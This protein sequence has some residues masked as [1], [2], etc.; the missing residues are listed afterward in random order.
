MKNAHKASTLAPALTRS[1]PSVDR[2]SAAPGATGY[3]SFGAW[4]ALLWHRKWTVG[5]CLVAG[6]AAGLA[7]ALLQTPVYRAATTVEIQLPNDD[8][9][10][11]RQL[12][13]SLLPG[14]MNIEP[15]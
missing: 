14:V 11:R 7:V 13:P 1:L 5:G 9:L 12:E 8:Y 2:P 15:F 10:N 4:R 3:L 6:L